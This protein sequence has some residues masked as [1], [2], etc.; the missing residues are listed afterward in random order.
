MTEPIISKDGRYLQ[1]FDKIV[2][3]RTNLVTEMESPNP[4]FVCEMYKN[5]FSF[6][7]KHSLMESN[8][9]FS[10]MRKMVYPL[11]NNTNNIM[12]YEMRFGQSLIVESS[13][14]ISTVKL[15]EEAWD[16]VKQKLLIEFPMLVEG[17]WDWVKEKGSQAVNWVKEKGAEILKKG[18]GGFF[19]TLREFL[20]SPVGIGLDIALT[21]IGVGKVASMVLW[22]A[23]LLWELKVLYSDGINFQNCLNVAFAALGVLLPALAKT[24]KAA[25]AGIK[26]V[27]K[28]AATSFGGKMLSS[29]RSGLTK[30]MGAISQGVE[31]LA[32]VFGPTVKSW[33]T[34]LMG[35]ARGFIEKVV[36]F[37]TPKSAM[38]GAKISTKM[39]GYA[40]QK[41]IVAGTAFHG[42]NKLIH[43][44]A[45]TETGQKAMIAGTNAYRKLT[46]QKSMEDEAQ[47]KIVAALGSKENMSQIDAGAEG[48]LNQYK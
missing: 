22:G 43:K 47:E 4:I 3:L 45:E 23:L 48:I 38:T 29:I 16:F 42:A 31:W 28:L 44:A 18:I 19:N 9:L 5:Q 13:Y 24:G 37:L 12:E 33:A 27:E 6:T 1:M 11:L 8:D 15:I 34:S 40:A 35:K 10:M 21:A 32:G 17:L 36:T 26:N 46:G 14:S 41:G 25:T 30:I 2:D 20:I 39:A 7:Y